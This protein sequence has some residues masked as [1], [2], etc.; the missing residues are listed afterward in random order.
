MDP[1]I[2]TYPYQRWSDSFIQP[3][4]VGA[5]GDVNLT[6]FLKTSCTDMPRRTQKAFAG[7]EEPHVG[8]NVQDG[9]EPNY[10]NAM[11]ARLIDSNWSLPRAR[12]RKIQNGWSRMEVQN[13]DLLTEPFV[14]FLGDFSWRNQVAR[15]NDRNFEMVPPG[16]VT[17]G[18]VPR[19]GLIPRSV[20]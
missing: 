15:I 13:P 16:E 3:G 10:L 4:M 5:I 8:S 6:P 17:S 14:S 7:D 12:R 2:D 20:Q 1:L 9:D 11:G 18:G 19:G